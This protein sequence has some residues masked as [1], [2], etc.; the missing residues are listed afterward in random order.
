MNEE[1]EKNLFHSNKRRL[2]GFQNNNEDAIYKSTK[3]MNVSS[4][5]NNN[6]NNNSSSPIL[7]K[8][9]KKVSVKIDN[10]FVQSSSKKI[11]SSN[12]VQKTLFD[13]NSHVSNN[14]D[15]KN[16]NSIVE[17]EIRMVIEDITMDMLI[18]ENDDILNNSKAQS[19]NESRKRNSQDDHLLS[20][21][22][23]IKKHERFAEVDADTKRQMEKKEKFRISNRNKYSFL[24]NILDANKNPPSSENY[25]PRTLYIPEHILLQMTPFERQ[26]WEIK[27]KRFDTIIFFNKGKFYELMERDAEIAERELGLSMTERAGMRMCGMP[28][29]SFT[30]HCMK[31]VNLGYK[32]CRVIQTET[33]VDR[34]NKKGSKSGTGKIND[35]MLE[36]VVDRIITPGTIVEPELIQDFSTKYLLC[37]RQIDLSFGICIIDAASGEVR[38]GSFK[39]DSF[40]TQLR[41]L[42]FQLRAKEVV[43]EKGSL[44]QKTLNLLKLHLD[45]H[46]MMSPRSKNDFWDYQTTI[47]KLTFEYFINDETKD[48][49]PDKIQK[50]V[51]P[52]TLR[53]Y[54]DDELVIRTLGGCISYLE[55][56]QLAKQI[57]QQ[58]KIDPLDIYQKRNCMVLDSN[59]LAYLNILENDN[60]R[61]IKG[62][63]IEIMDN[64]STKFGKRLMRKWVMHPLLR[65]NEINDRLDCVDTF[66]ENEHLKSSIQ[67]HLLSLPDLERIFSRSNSLNLDT[68]GFCQLIHSLQST[69]NFYKDVLNEYVNE[70]DIKSERLKRML[71]LGSELFPD[72]SVIINDIIKSFNYPQ[73]MESKSII[74]I[75]GV[76]EIFDLKMKEVN[77]IQL[78]LNEYLEQQRIYFKTTSIDYVEIGKHPYLLEIPNK[79]LESKK[80]PESY[81]KHKKSTSKVSRFYSKELNELIP[82]MASAKREL[83]LSQI[84]VLKT[85]QK[86]IN[87]YYHDIW[88]KVINVLS[89][90]DCLLSLSI[91]SSF[92]SPMCRPQFLDDQKP[93]LEVKD[94]RHPCLIVNNTDGKP[95]IPNDVTVG[96]NEP[97]TILLTGP[98]MGGKSTILRQLCVNIIMA[99]IGCYTCSESFTLTPVD[100]I[101]T[102]IGANDN[103]YEGQSTF[104]IELQETSEILNKSSKDSLVILDELGR[105]TSTF[106]G[107]SIAYSTLLY[108]SNRILCRTLFSTHFH[109]LT[110]EFENDPKISLYHMKA[111]VDEEK[112]HVLFLYKMEKGGCQKSYGLQVA[113]MAGL[114]KEI[115]NNAKERSILFKIQ[116][117]NPYK[118]L[119]SSLLISKIRDIRIIKSKLKNLVIK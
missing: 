67:S 70:C 43:F 11:P 82:L 80:I 74:P 50:E 49:G 3:E 41:T 94:M 62:T 83:E 38:I 102:R 7:K 12:P 37:L 65:I 109:M 46:A 13:M 36:R 15:K 112:D 91:T 76:D 54:K 61:G 113:S 28:T 1:D 95:F 117:N 25:D 78:K 21:N 52:E 79:I 107:Y 101:F 115:I 32:V 44:P 40:L 73:A 108:I 87:S 110:D 99:Q 68:Q 55:E 59:A 84:N 57:L 6:N 27:M 39:D 93:F 89:E 18:D 14:N 31:L 64:C 58:R 9:P 35:V 119:N 20:D 4:Y 81:Q 16:V 19:Q 42:L 111:I 71:S 8:S 75:E 34:L 90:I 26:Y 86:K 69:L 104:M 5:F 48:W 72:Y 60:D 22:I 103:I 116:T 29:T 97:L 23:K 96:G 33:P 51:W 63:L 106:D 98:N 56:V 2:I 105:G 10:S 100:R 88:L 85:F 77:N 30:H 53:L 24:D 47:D 66:L 118:R 45:K 92:T 17:D 114:P